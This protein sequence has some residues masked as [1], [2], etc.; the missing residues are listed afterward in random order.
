M[1]FLTFPVADKLDDH[2]SLDR[3]LSQRLVLLVRRKGSDTWDFPH[4]VRSDGEKMVDAAK[5]AVNR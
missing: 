3:A 1:D 4:E 2:K 5:R